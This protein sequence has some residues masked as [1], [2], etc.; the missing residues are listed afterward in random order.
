MGLVSIRLRRARAG[1]LTSV[2]KEVGFWALVGAESSARKEQARGQE[3]STAV[4]LRVCVPQ[5][6]PGT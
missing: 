1:E 4:E 3:S 2:Q 5:P 6:P